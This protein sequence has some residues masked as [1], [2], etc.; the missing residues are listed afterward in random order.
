VTPDSETCVRPPDSYLIDDP[1]RALFRVDRRVFTD[2]TVFRLERERIFSTCWLYLG[3]ASELPRPNDFVTRSIAGRPVIIVRDEAGA[4]RAYL[5]ACRHRGTQVC[6]DS[7]GNQTRFQCPYHGWTYANT[8]ELIGLPGADAYSGEFRREELGLVPAG[9]VDSYRNFYFLNFSAEA[10]PLCDYLGDAR[11]YLDLICDQLEGDWEV[12]QGSYLHSMQINWKVL[13]DNSTDL[14]HLPFAHRRYLDFLSA[15][16]TKE[17]TFR[18]TGE[19]VHLG[20]GHAVAKSS[21]PSGGRPIAWCAPAFP[22]SHRARLDALRADLYEKFGERKARDMCETN[23]GLFI[24]PNLIVNDNMAVTLRTFQPVAVDR[25]AIQLWALAPKDEAPEARKLR[26]DSLLTF[27]GP[28]GFGTPDDVEILESCQR[29]YAAPE[30]RWNDLSRGIA[31]DVPL[32]TD[33]HQNRI[34]WREWSRRVDLPAQ[35][36]AQAVGEAR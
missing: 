23:R 31:R 10:E 7:H 36:A 26:L 6:A 17:S 29:A 11:Y 2:E 19:V 8:G 3:H 27:V 30:I 16:G 1:E 28:G 24:F 9:R 34:F 32:H 18:R 22:E 12:V 4:I 33:E 15:E 20:G 25:I 35:G 14:Y 5:N 21:P 13:A